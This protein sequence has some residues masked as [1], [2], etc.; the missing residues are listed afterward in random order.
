VWRRKGRGHLQLGK[1][2]LSSSSWFAHGWIRLG[3][4][5]SR[6]VINLSK[7]PTLSAA[8]VASFKTAFAAIDTDGSGAIDPFEMLR[9]RLRAVHATGRAKTTIRVTHVLFERIDRDGNGVNGLGE[10]VE[11]M[12]YIL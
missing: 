5:A 12:R 4:A 8:G 7:A 2:S 11:A 6:Q 10:F 9:A 3:I 1:S